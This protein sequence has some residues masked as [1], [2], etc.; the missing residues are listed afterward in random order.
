MVADTDRHDVG[1]A[2]HV[3]QRTPGARTMVRAPEELELR[4]VE[5][6]DADF[7]RHVE[8]QRVVAGSFPDSV[9]LHV[10]ERAGRDAE[11]ERKGGT[12]PEAV[13]NGELIASDHPGPEFERCAA[14]EACRDPG[15]TAIAPAAWR[16][17][18]PL[19]PDANDDVVLEP[20]ARERQK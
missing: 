15:F 9:R 6:G 13:E 1:A 20:V 5:R 2:R 14:A 7:R 11:A 18:E 4:V 3:A 19:I 8:Q 16:A 17:P 12:E 10:V